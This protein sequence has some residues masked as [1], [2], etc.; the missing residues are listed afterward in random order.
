MPTNI[1]RGIFAC[2]I[3]ANTYVA[4]NQPPAVYRPSDG[5]LFIQ[6]AYEYF[7]FR[8]LI[9]DGVLS[10]GTWAVDS[11]GEEFVVYENEHTYSASATNLNELTIVKLDPIS[12]VVSGT[13]QFDFEDKQGNI[14]QIRDG[15][16][17]LE[18]DVL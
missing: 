15:R 16:F 1:G 10:A 3:D 17:D 5:Y 8:L 13:F 11:T 4:R 12:H 2:H 18:M 7:E 9:Y 14:K 6:T